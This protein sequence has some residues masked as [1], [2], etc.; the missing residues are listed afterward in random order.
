MT[1][2]PR[3][4]IEE[5]LRRRG[6][7]VPAESLTDFCGR[8]RVAELALFGSILRED[9]GPKSDIDVMVRFE[10]GAAWRYYHLSEMK[11][12]LEGL[13]G[14]QVDVVE[15][16]VVEASDNYIRRRHILEHALPIYV[17]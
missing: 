3:A 13:F 14:R 10:P 7:H 1:E 5:L 15:R 6:L 9:F 12:E 16:R 17:A 8:W 4:A 11:E 2:A